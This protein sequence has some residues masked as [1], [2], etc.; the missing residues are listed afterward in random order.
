MKDI[1]EHAGFSEQKMK[2][3]ERLRNI[4]EQIQKWQN[5]KLAERDQLWQARISIIRNWMSTENWEVFL[6]DHPDARKWLDVQP[7]D[8]GSDEQ[9]VDP[10]NP[11]DFADEPRG[12]GGA[13]CTEWIENKPGCLLPQKND[14]C[15]F[16]LHGGI[17]THIG[18][19]VKPR[20]LWMQCYDPVKKKTHIVGDENS[21]RLYAIASC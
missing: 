17:E 1:R 3:S 20:K 4:R 14:L 16:I 10:G 6:N 7:D 21:I 12:P 5:R 19:C 11:D 2:D 18:K 8:T 9:I 15:Y 13:H